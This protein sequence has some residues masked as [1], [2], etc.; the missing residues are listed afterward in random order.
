MKGRPWYLD[1]DELA[2]RYKA[3]EKVEAIAAALKRTPNSVRDRVK[4][5]RLTRAGKEPA[6]EKAGARPVFLWE[7]PNKRQKRSC[8]FCRKPFMSEGPGNRIC[9][10]CK[11]AVDAAASGLDVVRT[12][13]QL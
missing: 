8:L 6:I 11:P 5:R 7:I 12:G 3:G 1:D 4:K 2:R 10:R 9:K 13:D